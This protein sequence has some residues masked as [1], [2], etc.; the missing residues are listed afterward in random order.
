MNSTINKSWR[1]KL[2][3]AAFI[4]IAKSVSAEEPVMAEKIRDI[5]PGQKFALRISYDQNENERLAALAKNDPGEH[6]LADGMFSR[7]VMELDLVSLPGKEKVVELYNPGLGMNFGDIT[8]LWSADSRWFA[9]Y[10]TQ[11]GTGDTEVYTEHDG[12]FV[13]VNSSANDLRAKIKGNFRNEW[14]RPIKWTQP[15]TLMMEDEAIGNSGHV[16]YELTVKID[17]EGTVHVISQKKLKLKPD[18]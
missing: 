15:G 1:L 4:L 3:A 16:K 13:K 10:V 8:L 7:S 18:A 5:S 12:K 9:F 2:A 11:L 17:A 6:A 14:I